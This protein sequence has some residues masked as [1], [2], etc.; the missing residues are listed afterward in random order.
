VELLVRKGLLGRWVLLARRVRLVYLGSRVLLVRR[1]IR[2]LQAQTVLP[3]RPEQRV[4]R[5]IKAIR[6]MD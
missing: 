3:V 4:T 2:A 1:V 6:A 5:E